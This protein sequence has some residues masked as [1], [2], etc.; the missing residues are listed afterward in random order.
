VC[1]VLNII[2]LC[3]IKYLEYFWCIKYQYLYIYVKIAKENRKKKRKRVF[4]VS[5]ARGDSAQ[6]GARARPRG[7]PTQLGL[8]A[9]AAWGRRRGLEPTC[10][11]GGGGDEGAAGRE[12]RSPELDDG[13]PPVIRFRV[14]GVVA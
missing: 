13:S 5:W 12:N 7:Q 9:G 14:V 3:H 4:L 6:L 11:Q 1:Q 8:P 10:Q 2:I